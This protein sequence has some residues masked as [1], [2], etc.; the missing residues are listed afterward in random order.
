[1]DTLKHEDVN[2]PLA[3]GG[4]AITTTFDLEAQ[5][6]S[7]LLD[8]LIMQQDNFADGYDIFIGKATGPNLHCGEIHTGDA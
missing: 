8:K 4:N 6:L 5:I 2:V 1:M 3:L 7:F